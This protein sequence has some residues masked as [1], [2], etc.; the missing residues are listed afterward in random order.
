MR[1]VLLLLAFLAIAAPAGA[2]DRRLSIADFDRVVVEGPYR[3][4]LVVG[5]PT[6]GSAS[7]SPQALEA[8]SIDVQGMTL[9]IRRNPNAWGSA[10]AR[11][12]DS[13]SITL[14]TRSLRSAR[15]IGSG[16]LDVVGGRGLRLELSLDGNGRLAAT[17]LQAD[18]LA[19]ASRGGGTM[20]LEGRAG[21]VTAS[22]QGSGSLSAAGLTAENATI[23]A[24]TTGE[25]AMTAR[26]SAT[27]TADGLGGV[28]ISGDPACTVRGSG[29]ANVRCGRA[30]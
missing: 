22:V 30:R 10:P 27:V 15:L 20:S 6:S 3:V 12:T 16:S 29:A 23:G 14:A 8:V 4:R 1:F 21:T 26:R 7:G 9:R 2:A 5:P 18:T 25:V 17:A 19:V 28:V 24:A 11:A 13:V